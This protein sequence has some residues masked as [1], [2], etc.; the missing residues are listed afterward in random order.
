MIQII[1]YFIYRIIIRLIF[2]SEASK[3]NILKNVLF[4]KNKKKNLVI[5]NGLEEKPLKKKFLQ[6]FKT[7]KKLLKIGVLSRVEKIKGHE[8]IINSVEKMSKL[9]RSKI[10]IYFIGGGKKSYVEN[11]KRKI[12]SINLSENFKF[13]GYLREESNLILSHLI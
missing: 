8:Q 5:Y 1:N 4:F 7:K 3:T 13:C 2:V 6:I 9:N 12:K 11:L 10:I